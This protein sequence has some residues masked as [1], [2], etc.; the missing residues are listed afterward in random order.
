MMH[1]QDRM[2]LIL[3]E[4]LIITHTY[5]HPYHA[6]R[7]SPTWLIGS[8]REIPHLPNDNAVFLFA[9]FS[10]R[11]KENRLDASI[12]FRGS[13]G[14]RWK[15]N[16]CGNDNFQHFEH[17]DSRMRLFSAKGYCFI[18]HPETHFFANSCSRS[19]V[20]K[21]PSRPYMRHT[22]ATAQECEYNRT[23]E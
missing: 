22:S 19:L 23:R 5:R 14:Y 3:L 16:Q 15:A 9:D 18:Q 17:F 4:S 21:S 10:H 7:K 6:A 2:R 8:R 12:N 1:S 11:D 13:T 20:T